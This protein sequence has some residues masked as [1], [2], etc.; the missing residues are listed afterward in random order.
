M[1]RQ[2][3]GN[4]GLI[5]SLSKNENGCYSYEGSEFSDIP[6]GGTYY[7]WEVTRNSLTETFYDTIHLNAGEYKTYE[8]NY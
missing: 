4:E 6:M 7:K 3:E 2:V 5:G 1:G 8:I